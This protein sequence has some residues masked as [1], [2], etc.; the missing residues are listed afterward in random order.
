MVL[1]CTSLTCQWCWASFLLL[2]CFL[3][4]TSQE[5]TSHHLHELCPLFLFWPVA[6]LV[7]GCVYINFYFQLAATLLFCPQVSS[8]LSMVSQDWAKDGAR[9][10]MWAHLWGRPEP[11]RERLVSWQAVTLASGIGEQ[12]VDQ[13]R[14]LCT[15]FGCWTLMGTSVA[16]LT[17]EDC[18]Q[19]LWQYALSLIIT[20]KISRLQKVLLAFVENPSILLQKSRQILQQGGTFY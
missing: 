9:K 20:W 8:V 5:R 12:V 18:L 2:N 15:T 11:C 13:G 10:G 14:G 3:R 7:W 6:M 17:G 19:P 16:V 4:I 1:T